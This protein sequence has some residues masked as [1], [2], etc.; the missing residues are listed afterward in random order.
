MRFFDSKE[1]VLDIQL[2]Q[3]GKKLL[4]EGALKPVYYAFFDNDILYDGSYS[5]REEVQN[6]IDE[7]IRKETP[8]LKAQYIFRGTDTT[9]TLDKNLQI[10][11]EKNYSLGLPLGNSSLG[12]DKAPAWDINFLYNELTSSVDYLSGSGLSYVRIPQLETEVDFEIYVTQKKEDGSVTTNYIPERLVDV[13][14]NM[15]EDT[16]GVHGPVDDEEEYL[17]A[18]DGTMIQIK[19]DFVLLE[20]EEDNTDSMTDNFEIEIFEISNVIDENGNQQKIE[21]PLEFFNPTL[22]ENLGPQHIEYYFNLEADLDIPQEFF[23]ASPVV[24]ERK[25]SRLVDDSLPYP[26]RCPEYEGGKDLY[27]DDAAKEEEPC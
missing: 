23:C 8:R 27:I 4:S 20:V 6:T 10:S 17:L 11:P 13:A 2:T 26:L 16:P 24:K 22:D 19:P 5:N 25:R 15:F 1:E 21:K 18:K 9:S 14:Y 3:H 7:R 12:S